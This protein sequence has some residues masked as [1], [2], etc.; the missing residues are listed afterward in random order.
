MQRHHS[1]IWVDGEPSMP[2]GANVEIAHS[3]T[4]QDEHA[5]THHEGWHRALEILEVGLLAVVAIVTAWSGFQ[6]AEWDG[7]QSVLYGHSSADRF[8][9]SEATTTGDQRLAADAGIFTAWLQAHASGDTELETLLSKRL[10]PDYK[11]A[12]DAWLATDPFVDTEAPPGPAAMSQY[13]NPDLEK[14]TTLNASARAAFDE[15][16]E[17]RETGEKYVRNTVLFAMVLFL[18]A[19]AQRM[20]DKTL[21]AGVNAMAV[22]LAIYGMVSVVTLPRL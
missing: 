9:A 8:E 17:A 13:E 11:V 16:T 6:A 5:G 20:K 14:A 12:F 21:R 19:I 22:L 4:E 15:G 10:S 1:G 18:V 7:R 2:E 3:L